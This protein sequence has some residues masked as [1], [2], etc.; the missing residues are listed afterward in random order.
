MLTRQ[1]LGRGLSWAGRDPT[2]HPDEAA[3]VVPA[4]PHTRPCTTNWAHTASAP[5]LLAWSSPPCSSLSTSFAVGAPHQDMHSRAGD[6]YDPPLT[7]GM[8]VLT[9][10]GKRLHPQETVASP[11]F[12]AL[13]TASS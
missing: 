10:Q 1:L 3:S 2:S 7:S 13:G 12:S 4:A 6:W 11:P 5:Q 9:P 8:E